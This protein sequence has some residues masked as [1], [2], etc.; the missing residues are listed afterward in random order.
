[1]IILSLQLLAAVGAI[2]EH[3]MQLHIAVRAVD[4]LSVVLGMSRML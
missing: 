4:G 2:L 1:M 3:R